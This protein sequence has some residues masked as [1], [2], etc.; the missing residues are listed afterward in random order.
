MS[1]SVASIVMHIKGSR[2]AALELAR[3]RV[4]LVC[5]VFV[6]AYAV[7]GLRAFDLMI[8]Q[9]AL[10]GP[11]HGTQIVDTREDE[12]PKGKRADIVDRNGR[13]LARSLKA[14]ALY[15]DP[16]LIADPEPVARK[17]AQI[18]KRPDE[19][20]ILDKLGRDKRFV[21][22][23]RTVTPRQQQKVLEIGAPGLAF[24][25]VWRRVY[26]QRRLFAHILGHTGV[27]N[28]GLAGIERA[29]DQRL[30]KRDEQPLRLSLDVR[31]QHI[32]RRELMRSVKRFEAEG[33]AGVMMNVNTGAVLSAVS[34]P[35][36]D[37]HHPS[38]AAYDARFNR[39]THGVYEMGSTFKIFSTAALLETGAAD[40][41]T[42]FDA[43]Q[44]LKHGRYKIHDYHGKDR[45][46]SLPEVFMYSS[47]IGA[48][49]I[50]ERVGS[51]F[52]QKFYADLGL[53]DRPDIVLPAVGKPL[54]P[55]PWREINTL[56]AAYGH[57]VA[58]SPMQLASAVSTVVNGG[59][60][61]EP[62]LV[63]ERR[64]QDNRDA[65]RVRV[66]SKSTSSKMRRLMRL[67]VQKGTGQRA[68]VKGYQVGGKT[69]T[70][71]K[72][73]KKG[74]KDAELIASFIGVFPIDN[75]QYA[76]F[77][78]V[79]EP[80]GQDF[81]AG[82]ATGGWVAAPAVSRVISAAGPVLGMPR[83][84]RA[85]DD[86]MIAPLMRHVKLDAEKAGPGGDHVAQ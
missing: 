83:Q 20:T 21:W 73:G 18:F 39:A 57:G 11:Q 25:E 40:M 80:K 23:K 17:L 76:V 77:V 81:S 36:F 3:N 13:L 72:A 85:G 79:D 52:M 68:A 6:I 54:Y 53:F 70:A 56:T 35:D 26:P 12:K 63:A 44:P 4:M 30:R 66:L 32:M 43:R 19:A 31:L 29:F 47:N 62:H 41:A 24:R 51:Q 82:Y 55:S 46:L 49:R 59:L 34:L 7:L 16:A 27:D 45:M 74:Y 60:A 9:G 69:G 61:L 71:E 48:A 86:R 22:I 10:A 1:L 42:E 8:M 75:P 58:V 50:G 28:R 15:A 65:A 84:R 14:R 67:V 2:A 37:P 5:G 38:G 64:G 78:M 33:G